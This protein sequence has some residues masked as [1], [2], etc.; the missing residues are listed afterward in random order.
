M[1]SEPEQEIWRDP[2]PDLLASYLSLSGVQ[3]AEL[4][5]LIGVSQTTVSQIVGRNRPATI[6]QRM[7]LVRVLGLPLSA[8]GLSEGP[9]G[10]I[11]TELIRLIPGM[12]TAAER[13]RATG[14]SIDAVELMEL[15]NSQVVALR[16][17][18]PDEQWAR[19][20]IQVKLTLG[21]IL[22]DVVSR[23]RLWVVTG[24][25]KTGLD[26]AESL[27]DR[28][29][30]F[31]GLL[32]HGNELRKAGQPGDGVNHLEAAVG[33]ASDDRAKNVALV[34][35]LRA[36]AE[37]QN[38]S[39]FDRTLRAL[40]D[41]LEDVD[42]WTPGFHPLSVAE[43]ELR[44]R[45]RLGEKMMGIAEIEKAESQ[46]I[47][48]ASPAPQWRA[49]ASLTKGEALFATGE[50]EAAIEQLGEGVRLARK[51]GLAQQ[52]QRAREILSPNLAIAPGGDYVMTLIDE[53]LATASVGIPDGDSQLP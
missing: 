30:I 45:I 27:G 6:E 44:G 8:V 4:G 7:K 29:L 22:G 9:R 24:H 25:T 23:N 43:I 52:L 41:S 12:T 28:D 26:M 16:S 35:L 53:G 47:G 48:H 42:K 5:H 11:G 34:P 49:I 13:L 19:A 36:Y 1:H 3:Q 37:T 17:A 38:R 2:L 51:F 46:V 18:N 40:K 33:A 31:S 20:S 10:S 32:R 39:D 14:D 21:L 50:P 15:L